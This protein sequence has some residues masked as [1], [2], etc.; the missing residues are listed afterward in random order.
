MN[1]AKQLPN[2]G[3][4]LIRDLLSSDGTSTNWEMAMAGVLALLTLLAEVGERLNGENRMVPIP[5]N[6][7]V[8]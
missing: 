6:M 7:T 2:Y 8:S 5:A 1:I 4:T 3:I